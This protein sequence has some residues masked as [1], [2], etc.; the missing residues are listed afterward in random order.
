MVLER[1]AKRYQSHK[2]L[3]AEGT[4]CKYSK[5]A[6]GKAASAVS[7]SAKVYSNKSIHGVEA[8]IVAHTQFYSRGPTQL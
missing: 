2:Y 5:S 1:G 4:M 3:V 8:P 7:A 6:G